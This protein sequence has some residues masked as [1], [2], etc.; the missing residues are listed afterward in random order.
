MGS[1]LY[2]GYHHRVYLGNVITSQ[3][4]PL[5][6]L[7]LIV[8]FASGGQIDNF[9]HIGGLIGGILFTMALGVKYKSSRSEMING[10]LISLIFIT[11]LV[12]ISFGIIV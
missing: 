9:A 6:V 4:I 10:W 3:I 12:L 2:F 5:I 8:G 7:N 1:L 11:F